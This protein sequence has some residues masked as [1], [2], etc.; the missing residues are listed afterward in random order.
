M[1]TQITEEQAEEMLAQTEIVE[2]YFTGII[3]Q[4]KKDGYIKKSAMDEYQDLKNRVLNNTVLFIH[5][6]NIFPIVDRLIE[7]LRGEK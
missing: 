5:H 7:E 6:E 3:R 1:I 2:E 4:W